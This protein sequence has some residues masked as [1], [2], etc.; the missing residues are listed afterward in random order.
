M[1]KKEKIEWQAQKGTHTHRKR[2]IDQ[3]NLRNDLDR[4]ETKEETV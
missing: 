2:D 4:Q 1:Q 3:T